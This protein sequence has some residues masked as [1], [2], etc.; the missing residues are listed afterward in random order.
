MSSQLQPARKQITLERTFPSAIEEVWSLW[1]TLDGIEAW[2]GPD[3]FRVKVRTLD[4]KPGGHLDYDMIAVGPEQVEFMRK[5][6]MATSTLTRIIFTEVDPPRRLA[7]TN[8]VDFVPGVPPYEVATTVE[9]TEEPGGVRL[10]LTLDAM[11]DAHWTEMAVKGW[12]SQLGKLSQ[13]IDGRRI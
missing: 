1:T 3:G 9:L 7:Y 5:A 13:L 4:L 11:H 8:M 10:V 6:G 2:W 12:E